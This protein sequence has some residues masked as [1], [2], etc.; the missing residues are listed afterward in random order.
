M[1]LSAAMSDPHKGPYSDIAVLAKWEH[2]GEKLH[3]SPC[4]DEIIS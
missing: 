1:S 3:T 4:D 2:D